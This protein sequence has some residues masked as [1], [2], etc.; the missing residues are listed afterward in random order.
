MSLHALYK[1]ALTFVI[2][3]ISALLFSCGNAPKANIQPATH[4]M[5]DSLR[6]KVTFEIPVANDDP[7]EVA[8]VLWAVPQ[9]RYRLELSGTMGIG[10]ASVLWKEQNWKV[11][12]PTEDRTLTGE[13][14]LLQIPGI[15]LPP[16]SIHRLLAPIWGDWSIPDSQLVKRYALQDKQIWEWQDSSDQ[17]PLT[18]RAEFL[19]SNHQLVALVFVNDNPDLQ[20]RLEPANKDILVWQAGRL[21]MTIKTEQVRRDLTWKSSIWKL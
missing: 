9:K 10:V 7:S 8:G 18:L 15:Q 19:T 14:V 11:Y 20:V 13:G 21:L 2:I 5:A 12:L 6:A 16:I 17:Q 3:A 4:T 1:W